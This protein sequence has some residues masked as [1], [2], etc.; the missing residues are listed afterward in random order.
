[1]IMKIILIIPYYGRL[2]E[3]ISLFVK[4]CGYLNGK[5]DFLFFTDDSSILSIECEANVQ[6]HITSFEWLRDYIASKGLGEL[7]SAYKLCDYRP[8]YGYIF[9]EYIK[10]Y[11][12]WGYCDV[13]TILGDIPSFLI[14]SNYTQYDR[15]GEKGHFT[16]YRNTKKC[17]ELFLTNYKDLPRYFDFSFVKNTTYPCHFDESGMNVLCKRNNLKYLEK[18]FALQTTI[19]KELHLHTFQ[20]KYPE[21]FVFDRGHIFCYTKKNESIIKDE[22]MYIHFQ[23]RKVLPLHG[24]CEDCFVITHL[25]FFP[26]DRGNIDKYI[27]KYGGFDSNEERDNYLMEARSNH[28]LSQM[29]KLR[30][31]FKTHGFTALKNLYYRTQWIRFLKENNMF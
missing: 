15:I 14:K 28:S 13:D 16:I 25:G 3:W 6:Y 23:N 5:I 19:E 18:D 17:R 4:S 2:P 21:L 27:L 12:Y 1:M 30:R 7:S 29:K 8:C 31:E 20:A 10:D 26:F 9:Q 22:Y 24:N 11:E